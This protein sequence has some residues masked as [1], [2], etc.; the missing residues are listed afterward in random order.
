MS[1]TAY[2]ALKTWVMDELSAQMRPYP[3]ICPEHI[4]DEKYLER[5][6]EWCYLCEYL[7][8]T[9][10]C[11]THT[12]RIRTGGSIL[13]LARLWPTAWIEQMMHGPKIQTYTLNNAVKI[14]S[15]SAT[16]IY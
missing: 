2:I 15:I 6:R 5:H 8:F 14:V 7:N 3:L 12:Q 11:V 9:F 10:G 1:K 13:T 4:P 16:L